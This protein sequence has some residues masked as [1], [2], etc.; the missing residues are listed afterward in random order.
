MWGVKPEDAVFRREAG[1]NLDDRRRKGGRVVGWSDKGTV[2]VWGDE[3]DA[4]GLMSVRTIA[5]LHFAL[6]D[7]SG[8]ARL[9]N[10]L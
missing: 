6:I 3:Q 7:A 1:G 9:V 10:L 4:S 5:D 8:Q 2:H